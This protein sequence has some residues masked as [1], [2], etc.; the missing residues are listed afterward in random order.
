MVDEA[1]LYR[2]QL[3]Q[4]EATE[5]MTVQSDAHG[6]ATDDKTP[7]LASTGPE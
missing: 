7:A 2:E 6:S 5:P 4:D 3:S 1:I